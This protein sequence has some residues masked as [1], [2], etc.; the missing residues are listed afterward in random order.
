MSGVSE[1]VTLCATYLQ[2]VIDLL[3][4]VHDSLPFLFS[5]TPMMI[6]DLE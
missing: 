5:V 6:L 1:I 2:Q 4:I 3:I